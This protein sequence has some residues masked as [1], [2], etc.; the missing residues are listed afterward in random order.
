M[1][2]RK[3]RPRKVLIKHTIKITYVPD[4]VRALPQP[5]REVR[6]LPPPV[7]RMLKGRT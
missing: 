5:S 7:R 6:Q 3:T 2:K 1:K 4:A